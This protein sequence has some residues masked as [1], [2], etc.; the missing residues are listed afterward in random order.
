M[1]P[2][3]LLLNLSTPYQP[4]LATRNDDTSLDDV[5]KARLLERKR[6]E[7]SWKK[8]ETLHMESRP[9]IMGRVIAVDGEQVIADT[10]QVT[11]LYYSLLLHVFA[12]H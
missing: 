3:R 8:S 12:G 11:L 9:Y 5:I 10:Q 6:R 2:W 4:L 7:V 1:S